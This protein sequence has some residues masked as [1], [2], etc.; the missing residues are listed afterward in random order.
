MEIRGK[1]IEI[2]EEIQITDSF[3]KREF[4][5]EYAEN[6]QYPEYVKL[7]FIQDKCC[8]LDD[9]KKGEDVLVLFNLKGRKWT[10]KEGVD[11]YFNTLSAWKINHSSK[12]GNEVDRQQI[13]EGYALMDVDGQAD[14]PF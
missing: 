3:K 8:F 13:Q 5:I 7:E 11:I 12:G 2:F 14:L 9:F 1:I 6:P 10:N 4:V